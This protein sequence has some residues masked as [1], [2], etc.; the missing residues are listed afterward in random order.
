MMAVGS[1][2]CPACGAEYL[3]GVDTCGDCRVA[4]QDAPPAA[5]DHETVTYDLADWDDEQRQALELFLRGAD[6]PYGWEAGHDLVV[7]R[8][9]EAVVDELIEELEHRPAPAPETAAWRPAAHSDV[10]T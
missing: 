9:T 8:S 7:S 5:P 1:R 2:W 6:V 10:Q 3:A 4:L